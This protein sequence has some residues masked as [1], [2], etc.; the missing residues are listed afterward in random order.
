MLQELLQY[1]QREMESDYDE[2][3]IHYERFLSHLKFLVRR[4]CSHELLP[5][6]D[7]EFAASL[8]NKYPREFACGRKVAEFIKDKYGDTITEEEIMY[9][10]IHIKRVFMKDQT[11]GSR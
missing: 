8:E 6:D 11:E 3:S 4:V 10:A 9:L 2:D 5:D 7:M 1:I